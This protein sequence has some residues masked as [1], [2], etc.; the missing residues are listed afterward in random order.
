MLASVKSIVHE[1]ESIG[2]MNEKETFYQ[3]KGI[4]FNRSRK[5]N[6]S[7]VDFADQTNMQSNFFI[8]NMMDIMKGKEKEQKR[9]N[10]PFQEEAIKRRILSLNVS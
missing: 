7:M 6:N 1:N 3:S 10:I 2:E 4:Q 8:T 9:P 5:D